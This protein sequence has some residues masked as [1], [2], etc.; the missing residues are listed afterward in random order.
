MNTITNPITGEVIS[1][2]I[3]SL[4]ASQRELTEME[5]KI[6]QAKGFIQDKL[7]DLLE[8]EPN[9][10]YSNDE[11]VVKRVQSN[12]KVFNLDNVMDLLGDARKYKNKNNQEVDLYKPVASAVED[13]LAIRAENGELTQEEADRYKESYELKPSAPYVRIEKV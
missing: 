1:L 4:A 10:A 11:M 12:R 7:I 3:T 2:S 9:N 13:Y 5:K 6:K 8:D